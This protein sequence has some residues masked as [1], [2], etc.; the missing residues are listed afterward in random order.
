MG[1]VLATFVPVRA[2]LILA[3]LAS[4][5]AVLPL[6]ASPLASLRDIPVEGDART[7][8]VL[9]PDQRPTQFATKEA[10]LP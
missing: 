1:G 8:E 4:F 9:H 5:L 2:A 7:E 6:L 3:A 10:G